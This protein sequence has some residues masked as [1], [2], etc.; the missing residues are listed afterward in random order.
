MGKR[1]IF[2]RI[3]SSTLM[4]ADFAGQRAEMLNRR[5]VLA[6]PPRPTQETRGLNPRLA[7]ILEKG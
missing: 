4:C 3:A 2:S 7:R 1:G 6:T 5:L